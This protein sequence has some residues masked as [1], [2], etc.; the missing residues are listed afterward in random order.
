MSQNSLRGYYK[1]SYRFIVPE[2]NYGWKRLKGLIYR[3]RRRRRR[4]VG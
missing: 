1:M 3:R 2:I 4:K